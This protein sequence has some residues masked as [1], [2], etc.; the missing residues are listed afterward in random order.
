MLAECPQAASVVLHQS[1]VET[2][3]SR[4]R[5][6][7]PDG[8]AAGGGATVS[9][10]GHPSPWTKTVIAL[11]QAHVPH[12]LDPGRICRV[13]KPFVVRDGADIVVRKWEEFCKVG[14]HYPD[15]RTYQADPLPLSRL[16]PERFRDTY[17]G[18]QS[19]V[20]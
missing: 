18:W 19:E 4:D 3:E 2:E 14:R 5:E 9:T 13:L 7:L 12:A 8:L 1:R 20:A 15:G 17:D 6:D 11:Y 16:T 10:N